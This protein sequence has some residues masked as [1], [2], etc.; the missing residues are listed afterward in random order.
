M[1]VSRIAAAPFIGA[2]PFVSS[3]T[4]R[5]LAFVLFVTAA[6]TDYFDGHVARTR[7]LVTDLGRLLD[8]LADKLLLVATLVPML[9]LMAPHE[10][11]VAPLLDRSGQASQFAF[12]TPVGQVPLPWWIVLIVLSREAFMTIFRQAAARRGL[13]ISASGTAKW[14]T[15]FQSIWVG[16]AFFWFGASTLAAER[17]WE[18]VWWRAFANFNG[19]VGALAM[20]GAITLTLYSLWLYLR[21]YGRVFAN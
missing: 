18:S 11:W 15:A 7:N 1:T 19:V 5:F 8:P 16:S 21:Q 17:G 2:L 3:S 12:V 6:G 4:I 20:V 9:L 13:V 14:K 10:N